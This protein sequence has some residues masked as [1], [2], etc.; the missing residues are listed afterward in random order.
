M[1]AGRDAEVHAIPIANDGMHTEAAVAWRPLARVLVV[2]DAGHHLPRI[3]AVLAPEQRRGLHAAQ[4]ILLAAAGLERPDIDERAPV[5]L[6][7]RRRGLRLLEALP[8]VRRAQY[9][10]P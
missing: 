6:R 10:V 8:H 4:Q 9:L 5:V 2:A 7:K 1:A 3:A